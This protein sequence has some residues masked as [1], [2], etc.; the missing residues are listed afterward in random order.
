MDY[1][2]FGFLE[3]YDPLAAKWTGSGQ[4]FGFLNQ[5][6]AGL[7]NC[8]VLVESVMPVIAVQLDSQQDAD[9]VQQEI[10]DRAAAVFQDKVDRV[11]RVK[12][13]FESANAAADGVW[14]A[15]EPLLRVSRAD[16]T[17]FFRELTYLVRDVPGLLDGTAHLPAQDLLDRLVGDDSERAGS[18]PFYE[19][20]AQDL[21][22]QW[23]AWL[24][25]WRAALAASTALKS[26]DGS[27]ATSSVAAASAVYEQM[28]TANP[29]F[30]LR[31]WML[32]RAYQDAAVHQEREM[33]D[34]HELIKRPY[35]EGTAAETAR[36]YRRAP[37]E[38]LLTGGTAFMS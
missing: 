33:M 1:G 2:P 7:A 36:Y 29:K 5:P 32:V 27:I 22:D 17:L 38:A 31:E 12:L 20:L 9:R 6:N 26:R 8:N 14:E 18:S 13:G 23:T 19:P 16:W 3:E 35:G 37:D 34:L 11:F 25:E 21:R 10:L 28:R 4:H 15:L 24:D 30:V